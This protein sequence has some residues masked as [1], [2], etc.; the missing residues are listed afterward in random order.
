VPNSQ[1]DPMLTCKKLG[2]DLG[3]T[4][5][6]ISGTFVA[7]HARIYALERASGALTVAAQLEDRIGALHLSRRHDSLLA[8]LMNGKV[9]LWKVAKNGP[10]RLERSIFSFQ[11][12]EPLGA[13][14]CSF[15]SR[16]EGFIFINGTCVRFDGKKQSH[17]VEL[18][19]REACSRAAVNAQHLAVAVEGSVQVLDISKHGAVIARVPMADTGVIALSRSKLHTVDLGTG[20]LAVWDLHRKGFMTQEIELTQGHPC[21]DACLMVSRSGHRLD[22]VAISG[23]RCFVWHPQDGLHSRALELKRVTPI[24]VQSAVLDRGIVLLVNGLSFFSLRR[25]Y[26]NSSYR[27]CTIAPSRTDM[28]VPEWLLNKV[29]RNEVLSVSGPLLLS[30]KDKVYLGAKQEEVDFLPKGMID[31]CWLPKPPRIAALHGEGVLVSV[32]DAKNKTVVGTLTLFSAKQG[33][34][35]GG[36]GEDLF[37]MDEKGSLEKIGLHKSFENGE[38][39][40][41]SLAEDRLL[42]DGMEMASLPSGI[43]TIVGVFSDCL[44]LKDEGSGEVF[45]KEL[46]RFNASGRGDIHHRQI[47][48]K[49]LAQHNKISLFQPEA[50]ADIHTI[51]VQKEERDNESW[52][53]EFS[54]ADELVSS[55]CIPLSASILPDEDELE[56]DESEGNATIVGENALVGYW[57]FTRSMVLEDYCGSSIL[58]PEVGGEEHPNLNDCVVDTCFALDPGDDDEDV[59]TP[60][61]IEGGVLLKS[62]EVAK[63][64]AFTV[65]LW[66]QLQSKTNEIIEEILSLKEDG[67][68]AIQV[69]HWHHLAFVYP[70]YGESFSVYIDGQDLSQHFAF[71]PVRMNPESIS[72]LPNSSDCLLTEVRLWKEARKIFDISAYKDTFLPF[73]EKR[74]R[75]KKFEVRIRQV[76]STVST[77]IANTGSGGGGAGLLGELRAEAAADD[78]DG[79]DAEEVL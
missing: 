3:S 27:S 38:A 35:T 43:S 60:Q 25:S 42:L 7:I 36:I 66:L 75:P 71:S 64:N 58:I 28:P 65:E 17:R 68:M 29:G 47:S 69:G 52:G 10:P 11:A 19:V 67:A 9:L 8:V 41:W 45:A 5:Q 26:V 44:I 18:K 12:P 33:L 79:E 73:V 15:L 53:L 74:G 78:N 59:E 22:A 56:G 39:S 21:T 62:S 63:S 31:V 57:R 14:A 76:S 32:F 46:P 51:D 37:C 1:T 55:Y 61:A 72:I 77:G 40:I 49:G 50:A 70:Q 24:S 34:L 30:K 13:F 6:C 4:A 23:G 16:N 20:R 54:I 2:P 48:S